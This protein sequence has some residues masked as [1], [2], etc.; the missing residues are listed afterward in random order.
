MFQIFLFYV[1][2]NNSLAARWYVSGQW[3]TIPETDFVNLADFV[4][5]P[6][7]RSLSVGMVPDSS[8]SA[9]CLFFEELG[10]NVTALYGLKHI[11]EDTGT[12]GITF[13][14]LNSPNNPLWTWQNITRNVTSSSTASAW[15]APF[16][17]SLDSSS[18]G[19]ALDA[20][21]YSPRAVASYSS[22]TTPTN[23]VLW[24]VLYNG[25][26]D[27]S[28]SSERQ[29]KKGEELITTC[30]IDALPSAFLPDDRFPT[31]D[32]SAKTDLVKAITYVDKD[33]VE[34]YMLCVDGTTLINVQLAGL[35]ESKPGNTAL[36]PFP[37]TRMATTTPAG[38]RAFY[39]YHRLNGSILAEEV[40]D[41]GRLAWTALN[42]SVAIA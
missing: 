6:H 37:Y 10:S 12:H 24:S 8:S 30:N 1:A 34:N 13:D 15:N 39:L 35:G 3:A 7:S 23:G 25:S 32:T 11:H 42:I 14:A 26:F 4:A 19:P 28:K 40:W 33:S 16:T 29:Y 41:S 2:I 18:K 17:T 9:F 5:S 21:F 38:S 22:D 27:L 20:M 36:S 31:Q